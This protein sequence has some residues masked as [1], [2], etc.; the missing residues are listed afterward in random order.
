MNSSQCAMRDAVTISSSEAPGFENAPTPENFTKDKEILQILQAANT[1]AIM[2][3]SLAAVPGIDDIGFMALAEGIG[4][5]GE[6]TEE[7]IARALAAGPEHVSHFAR[8][9]GSDARGIR[10]V[11][12]EGS[13]G[14][15]VRSDNGNLF[16][17]VG[18][19]GDFLSFNYDTYSGT[20]NV[21]PRGYELLDYTLGGAAGDELRCPSREAGEQRSRGEHG[22]SG[23][24]DRTSRDQVGDP[25][26]EKQEAAGQQE[27]RRDDPLQVAAAKAQRLAD[28]R[29]RDGQH[30]RVEND[31][32]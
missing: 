20:L 32:R 7:Q 10:V 28:G 22:E 13:D 26:P 12:R 4:A 31:N 30:G 5:P 19:D 11:L 2:G 23:E 15:P 17:L 24:E 29:Q 8:I 18:A 14:Q 21:I 6:S 27:V 3:R 1:G 16:R 9:E 25:A